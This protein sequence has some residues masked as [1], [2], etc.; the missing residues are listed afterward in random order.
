MVAALG[1]A[2]DEGAFGLSSGLEYPLGAAATTDELVA[3]ATETGRRGGL[4][5]I[6]TR[7]RDF[8]AVEAFD[9][10]FAV[11]EQ[12]GAPFQ[13]SHIAPRVGAPPTALA[14]ALERI[15]RARVGRPRHRVRPAHPP[16]RDHEAH[17]DAAAVR[18]GAGHRAPARAASR[19]RA[20]ARFHAF[21][22]PIHKLGLMG[23]WDRL[24]LFEHSRAPEWVGKD[25]ATI[26]A[27][28]GQHPFDAIL[29]LLLE[30][31]DDAPNVL[32]IGLVQT[33]DDLDTAFAAPFCSP[34]SDATTL[35][36]DGPLASQRFL[37]AYTWAANYLRTAVRERRVV[38][39][40]EA[41]RRHDRPAGAPRGP[42]GPRHADAAAPP[43]TS[44]S[45]TPESIADTGTVTEPNA[46][47]NGIRAVL[48]NG[49]VA[50]DARAGRSRM[51]RAG[52]VL[53][54]SNG[55]RDDDHDRDRPDRGPRAGRHPDPRAP[56]DQ[57]LRHRA[58]L[59]LLRV[60]R[61][62][63]RHRRDRR[64]QGGRRPLDR[65]DDHDR[66]RARPRRPQADLRGVAASTS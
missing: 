11:A 39:L 45:S 10:A 31:G 4:Y 25:F 43:P 33:Q 63:P 7:D 57:P 54:R 51:R 21:R 30:A 65:R 14:D 40:E 38:T 49:R 55:G 2:M 42:R 60:R 29:D 20:R 36:T 44:R 15:D 12:S 22:E 47:A 17:D 46:Y 50:V 16:P 1:R 56:A 35:A 34:E 64:V 6:H 66:H 27:E 3:L 23:H 61:R 62:E 13:I 53:R 5:A 41:I 19:P 52:R 48:V 58:G 9:E 28:R 18:R 59:E 32:F 24:W 26:A 37:G 8:H